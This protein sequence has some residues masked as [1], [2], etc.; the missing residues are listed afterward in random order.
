[1]RPIA[2]AICD[3]EEFFVDQLYSL[4][5]TY[6]NESRLEAGVEKYLDVELLCEQILSGDKSYD[7]IFL[8][9]DMPK[10][11]GMAAAK[12][13]RDGGYEGII[14]FVTSLHNYALEAYKVEALG[15]VTKPAQYREVYRLVE[16]AIVQIHYQ[17][18]RAEAEKRYLEVKV[19]KND[20]KVDMENIL[21]VEKRRNQSVIHMEN[22]EVVCYEALNSLFH[23]L[24]QDKFCYCHQGFVVN[25]DKIMEV[26]PTFIAL[27]EGRTVPVSRRHQGRLKERL[28]CKIRGDKV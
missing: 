24:N 11:S 12:K 28:L 25:F 8:D 22:G 1:M 15:Y 19:H 3:D 16:K 21:Y 7:L 17:I 5:S 20:I 14:C 6:I 2:I 13:L 18:H 10:L 26:T 9:I 4:V 27:G 23:R